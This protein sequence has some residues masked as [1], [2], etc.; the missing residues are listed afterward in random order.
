MVIYDNCDMSRITKRFTGDLALTREEYNRLIA[1]A[2]N[3][4]DRLLL[5][6]GCSLGI[7][8][9]DIVRIKL[10]N[11]NF[12]RHEISYQEKKKGN[13]IRTVPIPPKLETELKLF[14]VEQKRKTG[15]IFSF[16][17]RQS[18]NRFASLCDKAGVKRRPIHSLRSTCIS[19][20]IDSGF[21]VG[22]AAKIIGDTES[23][24]FQHYIG[25]TNTYMNEKMR[26][27]II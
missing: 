20:L 23:T 4:E 18:W 22:E 14:M 11:I 12:D 10:E 3:F 19:F 27:V 24:V 9:S 13:R 1:V 16:K 6:I 8:R 7:R 25:C 26:S 2:D 15:N 21:S 17:D 5:M